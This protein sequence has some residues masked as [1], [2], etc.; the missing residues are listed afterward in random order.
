MARIPLKGSERAPLS[1]ARALAPC[2]PTE[3]F[4][5]S[6][7]LRRRG[8]QTLHDRLRKLTAGDRSSGH[9][10]REEFARQ[11]GAEASDFAAVKAFA[12]AHGLSVVQEHP[13]RRTV[14]L[15]GTVAQFE[16]AFEV[17]LQ[18]F[19]HRTGT[20]RGRT[21]PIHLPVE[22]DGVVDA[23]LGLDNRPQAKPHFRVRGSGAAA[24][25]R[26]SSAAPV[27]F[28]PI[29]LAGLYNFPSGTGQGVCVGIIE[30]GGGFKPAD[31]QT[32]FAKLKVGSPKVTAVSVDHARNQPTGD[33][34]GP[35][36]EVMLDIEVIGAIAPQASIAVYFAPN[37][38][39]GFLDAVTTAIHD[40]TNKPSV[41]SIS[42]GGPE[43]TWTEQAMTALDGAFQ[44]A[45]ALG[46]TVCV[47][48][49]DNG[50]SDAVTDG[51]DHVD[52]PASSPYALACGGTSLQAN[53]TSISSEVVWND[54]TAGGAGGGGVSGFFALPTWQADVRTT[55][56][57]GVTNPLTKRGVPDVSGDADPQTGY[58]VR[59]DGSDTVI[60]GTSAVAPL[61]AGLL[62]RINQIKG[63]PVG[64][65]QPQLY[66]NPQA[67]R[68]ITQGNNGDF[69]A[70]AAWDA[71]TGLGSPNGQKVADIFK[72]GAVNG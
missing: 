50:S 1:G 32:Y 34:N 67:L 53:Q 61:W 6:V 57:N 48:S 28:T 7:L 49:G 36:G 26:P 64:Y 66:Q 44:A 31:L 23:V 60:G 11:F 38:D 52:F 30:L 65:I 62:A 25:R 12:A 33:A 20:Y 37:T 2:D 55:N 27:A 22:L 54:G 18:Q 43:S 47:A 40:T 14:I 59:I 4:E 10:A 72:A 9:L 21:G 8:R 17:Q 13:A 41:I 56:A 51:A 46:V 29:Q 71:C 5:V 58:D 16:A 39:A 63:Q 69:S 19:E 3:R 42:W 24:G 35:D 70:S 68:D 45:A 15:A